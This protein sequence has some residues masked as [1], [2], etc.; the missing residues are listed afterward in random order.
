[1]LETVRQY[2]QD[3][4]NEAGEVQAA[5]NR[6]L[7]FCVALA[8]EAAPNLAGPEQG[9]WMALMDLERENFLAAHAWCDHAKELAESGLRLV[10]SL[11]TYFRDRFLLVLGY[12]MALHRNFR[13]G[14][15]EGN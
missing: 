3:R 1:M 9:A 5:R 7:D 4:L 11:W 15:A 6:H 12:R 10:F 8:E 13:R 2:A 14:T